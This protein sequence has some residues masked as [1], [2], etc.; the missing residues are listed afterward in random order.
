M[1]KIYGLSLALSMMLLSSCNE[2]VSSM[3]FI[4]T[5]TISTPA[6]IITTDASVPFAVPS[7]TTVTLL[8]S[9]EDKVLGYEGTDLQ[10]HK[11]YSYSEKNSVRSFL[12]TMKKKHGEELVVFIKTTPTSTYK[13]MVNALDEMTISKI[14]KYQIIDLLPEEKLVVNNQ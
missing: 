2:I 9:G 10:K 14:K 13:N 6:N 5:T 11:A 12:N 3:F 8:L 1:K 7:A 4:A